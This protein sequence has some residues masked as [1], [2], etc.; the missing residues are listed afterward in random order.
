MEHY[1]NEFYNGQETDD[2]YSV[3][4]WLGIQFLVG[5]PISGLVLLIIWMC[6]GK[7][8]LKTYAKAKLVA[9]VI[10]TIAVLVLASLGVLQ[11]VIRYVFES[12]QSI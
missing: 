10:L 6:T 7:P 4:K 3:G 9:G 11:E 12:G 5:I 8:T 1:N 2:V